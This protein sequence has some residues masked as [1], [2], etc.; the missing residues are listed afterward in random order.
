MK[1]EAYTK[2]FGDYD[3]LICMD[4]ERPRGFRIEGACWPGFRIRS[5]SD[6]EI[7]IISESDDYWADAVRTDEMFLL[8]VIGGQDVAENMCR[9]L[10]TMLDRYHERRTKGVM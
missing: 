4:L 9:D 8:D 10:V 2:R 7:T 3:L 1:F 6:F 5:G